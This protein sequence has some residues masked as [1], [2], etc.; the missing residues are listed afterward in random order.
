MIPGILLYLDDLKQLNGI[1]SDADLG[2]VIR[3]LMAYIESGEEANGLSPVCELAFRMIRAKVDREIKKYESHSENGEKGGRPKK[4]KK[5][6]ESEKKLTKA[7]E[8]EK[9]LTKANESE[10]KLKNQT[11]TETETENENENVNETVIEERVTQERNAHTGERFNAPTLDQIRGYVSRHR[12]TVDPVVFWHYYK[13][14]HWMMGP[15]PMY[16]WESA[17]ESWQTREGNKHNGKPPLRV[18]SAYCEGQRDLT[19]DDMRGTTDND[20]L[21]AIMEQ[22]KKVS[23]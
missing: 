12:L 21:T 2:M 13:A 11:E 5:A 23:G 7:N 3:A 19:E 20:I 10:R 14:R 22:R 4:L 17:L 16:D 1:L 15:T 8:S 9:K 6:N 18:L